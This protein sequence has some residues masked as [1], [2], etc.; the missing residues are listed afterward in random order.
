MAGSSGPLE[1]E[2][3]HIYIFPPQGKIKIVIIMES[4][5]SV[6]FILLVSKVFARG[7]G[8]LPDQTIR[9]MIALNRNIL[10]SGSLSFWSMI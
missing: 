5:I 7:T 10:C 3:K 9:P 1:D 4:S 8:F 2:K 6:G